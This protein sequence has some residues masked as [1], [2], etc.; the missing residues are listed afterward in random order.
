MHSIWTTSP[1]TV[2]GHDL[3]ESPA[4]AR[5]TH[6]GRGPHPPFSGSRLGGF[7]CRLPPCPHGE[8]PS[9]P[10][11]ELPTA[12]FDPGSS[13]SSHAPD[14]ST[15][16]VPSSSH[17][18]DQ[19]G[20]KELATRSTDLQ[21]RPRACVQFS[22]PGDVVCRHVVLQLHIAACAVHNRCCCISAACPR[23]WSPP[24]CSSARAAALSPHLM[25]FAVNDKDDGSETRMSEAF[26]VQSDE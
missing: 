5:R 9:F 8:P 26:Y 20:E 11:S 15:P 12:P 3:S 6:P 7:G 1:A 2:P 13:F 21:G 16:A 17:K 24:P 25:Q 18:S 14:P 19:T 22:S 10:A 4:P 23:A